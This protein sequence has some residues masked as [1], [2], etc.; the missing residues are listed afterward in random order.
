MSTDLLTIASAD[1]TEQ[2]VTETDLENSRIIAILRLL[3]EYRFLTTGQCHTL[4]D[5]KWPQQTRRDLA[6]ARKQQLIK[7]FAY[8]SGKGNHSEL[9]WQLTVKGIHLLEETSGLHLKSKTFLWR[10]PSLQRIQQ[11]ENELELEQQVQA[12][13]WRVLRPRTYNQYKPLPNYTRQ[14]KAIATALTT[15][16]QKRRA[17]APV[18]P[19]GPHTLCI[20]LKT[21]EYVAQSQDKSRVVVLILCPIRVGKTFWAERL[22][23]YG[24]LARELPVVA[25]FAESAR[26]RL[27]QPML[28]EGK[29]VVTTLDRVKNGL[30]ALG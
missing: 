17:G 10:K 8:Q 9:C 19:N 3:L 24:L 2:S 15:L 22:K 5:Q 23:K 1:I 13:S 30:I 4:L 6:R 25:V 16:E 7:S 26:A 12:A 14:Y 27:Y 11:R 29:L 18:D 20:P 28:E 21:N